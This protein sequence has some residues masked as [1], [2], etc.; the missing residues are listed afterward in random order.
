MKSGVIKKGRKDIGM[1]FSD[2][3]DLLR[4]SIM[5]KCLPPRTES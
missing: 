1:A 4:V 3:N 5:K 2:L